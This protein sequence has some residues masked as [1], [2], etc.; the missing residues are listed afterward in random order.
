[1]A[2]VADKPVQDRPSDETVRGNLG[3]YKPETIARIKAAAAQPSLGPMTADEAIAHYQ[4]LL[5]QPDHGR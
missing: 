1:M 4:R 5:S 2:K 3:V